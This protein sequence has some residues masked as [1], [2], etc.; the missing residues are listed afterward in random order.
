[1]DLNIA[2]NKILCY[3]KSGLT[4]KISLRQAVG[5]VNATTIQCQRPIPY[6]SYAVMDGY[7]IIKP[8]VKGK[9]P[10]DSLNFDIIYE[11]AAGD[12]NIPPL[13][14]EEAVKIMTGAA[15]PL[16][17]NQVV[18]FEICQDDNTRV[19]IPLPLPTKTFIRHQGSDMATGA[20]ILRPGEQIALSHLESLVANGNGSLSVF[21]QPE[22]QFF[23]TGSELVEIDTRPKAGQKISSNPYLLDTLIKQAGGSP[24][25]LGLVK[26]TPHALKKV[27][28][29]CQQ[30]ATKSRVQ[31]ILISTGGLGPGKYD[32]VAKAFLELGGKILYNTLAIRPGKSTLFGYMDN[33]MYFA[34]PGPPPAI[35][36]LFQV[37]IKPALLQIQGRQ[38][39]KPVKIQ[40][41]LAEDVASH[42]PGVIRLKEVK[43]AYKDATLTVRPTHPLESADALLIIPT[44]RRYIKRGEKVSVYLNPA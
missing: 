2:Q 4:E 18:P 34:L 15:I 12:T 20:V 31:Q 11:L 1:M 14:A 9:D 33:L 13:K 24:I 29:R 3:A 23:C 7:A 38:K 27:L 32:L 25:N 42:K 19:Q 26:D 16:G 17:A 35:S 39:T 36:T 28:S 21:K 8:K 43:I 30:Q 44:H 40:A 6:F 10:A 5:R 22:V 37:L 41:L